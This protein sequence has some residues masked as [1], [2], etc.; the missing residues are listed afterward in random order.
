M[1]PTGPILAPPMA[2]GFKGQ[3]SHTCPFQWPFRSYALAGAMNFD[4]FSSGA[5]WV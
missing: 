5:L 4:T 1:D 3:H 2:Y